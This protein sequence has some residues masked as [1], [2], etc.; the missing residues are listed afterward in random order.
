MEPISF[1]QTPFP[2]KFG[3][4]RQSLLI[5][6]AV[7]IM[8]FPKNDFYQEAFR[9]IEASSHLWLLFEFHHVNEQHLNGLVRPPRFAGKLKMGVF[10]TRSPHR[11]NRIGLSVVQ[12]EQIEYLSS[13]IKLTVSGV[14]VVDGTPIFDI[15]PY[16]PYCDSVEARSPF[17]DK[18]VFHPVQWRCEKNE[19]ADLIEKVIAL[20]PRPGQDKSSNQEYGVSM[21]GYNVRF[22]FLL[23]N[24]EI[25][26]A[27]KSE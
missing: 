19:Q 22:R 13:S 24:F 7:G 21:A 17:Q 25:I 1:I 4:P 12:F 27:I 18:P 10:A 23:G 2:E 26:S 8:S 9:G 11:P 15:K 20:D 3:V 5:K 6:E 16:V 14:D